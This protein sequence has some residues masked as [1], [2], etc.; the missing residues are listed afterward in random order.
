MTETHYYLESLVPSWLAA[1]PG[2]VAAL[3]E[4]LAA[5]MELQGYEVTSGPVVVPAH[6]EARVPVGMTLVRAEIGVEEFD[7]DMD[8]DASR[9]AGPWLAWQQDDFTVHSVPLDDLIVH[10]FTDDCPCGPDQ[11]PI[12]RV[13]GAQGWIV[14]H[15][16]LDGREQ[17]EASPGPSGG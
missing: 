3:G 14:R 8:D 1:D 5:R 15:H 7:L 2:Y 12:P 6:T 11:I 16:S 17:H 13:D 9:P 4:H 10:D